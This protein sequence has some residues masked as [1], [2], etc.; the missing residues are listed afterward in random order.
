MATT[1]PQ[2]QRG[3][4]VSCGVLWSASRV[5]FDLGGFIALFDILIGGGTVTNPTV[6]KTGPPPLNLHQSNERGC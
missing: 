4:P 6:I 3:N 1:A 2:S 5:F